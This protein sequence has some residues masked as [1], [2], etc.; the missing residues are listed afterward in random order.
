MEIKNYLKEIEKKIGYVFKDKTLLIQA[1]TRT[2]YCNE[3]NYGG[4]NNYESNEVLEFFGDAVLSAAIVSLLLESKTEKYSH[5]ITTELKE[6][7]FSNIRSK[8]SDKRNLSKSTEK[9]GLQKYLLLGEGDEKLGIANEASVM[10]DLFESIIGA[11]YIDCGMDIKKVIKVVSL[12]LDTSVYFS[13]EPTSLRS[14]KNALQEFCADK[15]RRL[16][17]PTYKTVGESGPDHRKEY[18]R[19]CY[20]GERLVA[21]GKG[22]NLKIADTAAAEEALRVLQKEEERLPRHDENAPARLRS[23]CASKKLSSPEW[24]DLGETEDSSPDAPIYSVEC[25][26][27]GVSA[28]GC[29]VSKSDARA[30]AA[31][32]ILESLAK[33][34][35]KKTAKPAVSMKKASEVKKTPYI[36]VSSPSKLKEEKNNAQKPNKTKE[37]NASTRRTASPKKA[38]HWHTKRS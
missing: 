12:I 8:L 20:V 9:L 25:R 33:N 31:E 4:R 37:K 24:R 26:A 13:S 36:K 23:L 15:H 22:K 17:A 3:K 2:S 5:G 18:E 16:P 29:G 35:K 7:D 10:E 6:G 34:E 30:A 21:V 1:F 28:I 27:M 11:I 19:A 14:P 32:M 38:P